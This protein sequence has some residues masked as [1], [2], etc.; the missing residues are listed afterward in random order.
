LAKRGV[1]VAQMS[2]VGI[3]ESQPIASNATEQGR[4]LNRRVEFMLSRFAEAIYVAIEQFQRNSEWLNNH[5]AE[6]TPIDTKPKRLVVIIPSKKIATSSPQNKIASTLENKLQIIKQQTRQTA[7]ADVDTV[8]NLTIKPHT[9]Q[10]TV[11]LPLEESTRI[12]TLLPAEKQ[13]VE[14]LPDS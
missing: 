3:G 10:T 8:T 7:K 12:V 13:T 1:N 5:A 14:L 11:V 4:S 9:K 6:Q 2:T